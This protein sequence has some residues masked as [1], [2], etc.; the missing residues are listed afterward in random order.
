MTVTHLIRHQAVLVGELDQAREFYGLLGLRETIYHGTPCPSFI[1]QLSG[2]AW[3]GV[4]IVK[5]SSSDGSVLELLRPEYSS[6]AGGSASPSW[7]H[8]AFTVDDCLAMVNRLAKEGGIQVGGPVTDPEAP[9][10]VA[11]LRDPWGNLLEIVEQLTE[12]AQRGVSEP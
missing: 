6:D 12:S 4:S 1:C 9:F 8:V 3:R 11:Y 7:N 5:L 10:R 2:G